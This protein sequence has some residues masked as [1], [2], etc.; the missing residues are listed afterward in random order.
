MDFFDRQARARRN[1]LF[2]ITLYSLSVMLLTGLLALAV[3]ALG[4]A[5]KAQAPWIAL[6]VVLLIA[7][8]ALYKRWTLNEGGRTVAEILARRPILFDSDDPDERRVLNVVEEIAIA[9]GAPVPLVYVLEAPSINAFAAGYQMEDAVLAVTRG[10]IENLSRAELQGMLAHEFSHILNGDMRLNMRLTVALHGLVAFSLAGRELIH[11]ASTWRSPG[12]LAP[13]AILAVFYLIPG[14]ALWLFGGAGVL[15]A[16]VIKAAANRQ[17]DYL[18]DAAAVQFTRDPQGIGGALRKLAGHPEGG[19]I[20]GYR[21]KEYSHLFFGPLHLKSAPLLSP[22]APL[23]KRIQRLLPNWD[24]TFLAPAPQQPQQQSSRKATP[25]IEQSLDLLAAAAAA[26]AATQLP[27]EAAE[28]SL[29]TVG[30]VSPVHLDYARHALHELPPSLKRAV[31]D[32]NSARA[33][34]AHLLLSNEQPLRDEQLKLLQKHAPKDTAMAV[35]IVEE[36][37]RQLDPHLRWPLVELAI[38]ALKRLS[39]PQ[40]E[41]FKA[42]LQLLLTSSGAANPMTWTLYRSVVQNAEPQGAAFARYRLSDCCREARLLLSLFVS[43]NRTS[44]AA[45]QAA[46]AAA[47]ADLPVT[48][49]SAISLD[50]LSYRDLDRAI[51]KLR[52]LKPSHKKLLLK[53]LLLGIEHNGAIDIG[54]AELL[55]TTAEL[56]GCPVPPLIGKPVPMVE[57]NVR[58][59]AEPVTSA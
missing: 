50:D 28:S 32:P 34:I 15:C 27:T 51:V 56:L 5:T 23:R 19:W 11:T 16:N 54:E 12:L 40:Y 24:G 7:I 52:Q 59:G 8:A 46:F 37:I 43:A 33:V 17:R 49:A 29:D 1:A 30:E 18:A 31:R 38:P 45:R 2:L 41:Q 47:V 36:P 21:A 53:S 14:L 10:A 6:S 4:L 13:T 9:A 20:Q 3:I 57:E 44:P 35:H 39:R 25:P 42:K 55:R 48:S 26:Y 22:H 58:T